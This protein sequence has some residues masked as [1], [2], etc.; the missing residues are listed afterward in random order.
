MANDQNYS[1]LE[2]KSVAQGALLHDIG[3][4]RIDEDVYLKPKLDEGDWDVMKAH[5]L[6]GEKM[7]AELSHLHPIV[8]D[9][10]A[11]HHS[12]TNGRGYGRSGTKFA[13]LVGTVDAFATMIVPTPYRSLPFTPF[14]AW[15][16]L[17]EDEGHFDREN[18]ELI[19]STLLQPHLK[20]AS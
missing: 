20:K 2:R 7:L 19:K 17:K 4:L 12:Q 8:L 15:N 9:I 6:I 3:M 10:I 18:V 14:E 13:H 5:P 1:S 11:G 16:K